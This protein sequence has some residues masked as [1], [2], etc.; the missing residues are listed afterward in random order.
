MLLVVIFYM[1]VTSKEKFTTN[2]PVVNFSSI[3]PDFHIFYQYPDFRRQALYV[4]G[5]QGGSETAITRTVD[6]NG[7]A[8]YPSVP[9][10]YFC[11]EKLGW[12]CR[13]RGEEMMWV[14]YKCPL[15]NTQRACNEFHTLITGI[16]FETSL[17]LFFASEKYYQAEINSEL[18]RPEL[19]SLLDDVFT[20]YTPDIFDTL[21]SD[22]LFICQTSLY[23]KMIEYVQTVTERDLTNVQHM[24]GDVD[25]SLTFSSPD[26][27]CLDGSY[28]RFG[29]KPQA[30][31]RATLQ[32]RYI[33]DVLL[34]FVPDD[35]TDNY[36]F[37]LLL[38]IYNLIGNNDIRRI[39]F[40]SLK[41]Y[42]NQEEWPFTKYDPPVVNG[43]INDNFL[44]GLTRGVALPIISPSCF[45]DLILGFIGD[46]VSEDNLK[47]D[48]NGSMG[49]N[50][51]NILGNLFSG[52]QH[53]MTNENGEVVGILPRDSLLPPD[54]I[55]RREW[56][57]MFIN[58]ICL[59]MLD[60][61]KP[62]EYD[63][64]GFVNTIR[65]WYINHQPVCLRKQ[66]F[67][68]KVNLTKCGLFNTSVTGAS[69]PGSDVYIDLY[70]RTIGNNHGCIASL[71][72]YR[73]NILDQFSHLRF[74]DGSAYGNNL[75]PS[76]FF[77]YAA[78]LVA[79]YFNKDKLKI[80]YNRY[81]K[82]QFPSILMYPTQPIINSLTGQK[83]R[84]QF[85]L[86]NPLQE[87]NLV[88]IQ[89]IEG[90]IKPVINHSTNRGTIASG[91]GGCRSNRK[92]DSKRVS[93]RRIHAAVDLYG[94]NCSSC[95][96]G[97]YQAQFNTQSNRCPGGCSDA[98]KTGVYAPFY[99]TI[100]GRVNTYFK[101]QCDQNPNQFDETCPSRYTCTDVAGTSY[102]KRNGAH[103]YLPC[104]WIKHVDGTI[105][106]YAEFYIRREIVVGTQVFAGERIGYLSQYTDQCHTELYIGTTNGNA[107]IL[108]GH[109]SWENINNR[110]RN[111]SITISINDYFR[112]DLS[113]TR[114]NTIIRD[115]RL[116]N[117]NL[118]TNQ[119]AMKLELPIFF[120]RMIQQN[121]IN[122]NSPTY[123]DYINLLWYSYCGIPNRRTVTQQR[124]CACARCSYNQYLNTSTATPCAWLRRN[125]LVNN[126]TIL[127]LWR[128]DLSTSSWITR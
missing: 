111:R 75:V 39:N 51:Q 47:P 60:S 25:A 116:Q 120:K 32:V 61:Y 56:K 33:L 50:T 84:G 118:T 67:N 55:F 128:G 126:F 16:N 44:S 34:D 2:I 89:G 112:G 7:R 49:N 48:W 91:F 5:I 20:Y 40:N 37:L 18:G 10:R 93:V 58:K 78:I 70:T 96:D 85:N 14:D 113:K 41:P 9:V 92:I 43:N 102:C 59:S 122:I 72:K 106:V 104:L 3:P 17:Q 36:Q 15:F 81:Y 94:P 53:Q 82:P 69:L 68:R 73:E 123:F 127:T 19:T 79:G 121:L 4:P 23:L 115:S 66:D 105:G 114:F 77:W 54:C 64:Y 45:R 88:R 80:G 110:T 38:S 65:P 108:G 29:I 6:S 11:K 46:G 62:F 8:I 83:I 98:K 103:H 52:T 76:G 22:L 86:S 42:I 21:D 117:P 74:N 124:T 71:K 97:A 87:T 28:Y 13:T 35:T 119:I 109:P 12:Y 24:S 107:W 99:G 31:F 95:N 30:R 101:D 27:Q 57:H 1:E 26:D 125:D 63:K 100:I 90:Y